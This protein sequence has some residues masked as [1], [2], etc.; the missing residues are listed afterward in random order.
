MIVCGS[1]NWLFN[2]RGMNVERS[3]VIH[4]K[5]IAKQESET[6]I[7]YIQNNLLK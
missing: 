2:A 4:D 5:T 1:F 6:M 7:K 3:Y